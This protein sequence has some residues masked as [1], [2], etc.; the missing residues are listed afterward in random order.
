MPGRGRI[1][2]RPQDGYSWSRGDFFN[3]RKGC[4]VMARKPTVYVCYIGGPYDGEEYRWRGPIASLVDRRHGSR[5]H[6][7]RLDPDRSVVDGGR[8]QVA[9]YRHVP[10]GVADASASF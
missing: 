4:L 6:L 7:Y 5:L 8:L 3:T 10:E 2:S 9:T 1:S